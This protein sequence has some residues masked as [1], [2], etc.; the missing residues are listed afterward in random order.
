MSD[1]IEGAAYLSDYPAPK[2]IMSCE[3]CG[4]RVQYDKQAMLDAGGD[5]S[6]PELKRDIANRHHC[7][8]PGIDP[9]DAWKHCKA[10]YENAVSGYQK[11]KGR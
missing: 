2:L 1:R 9:M 10:S 7:K 4:W 5:R 8:Q 3:L 6:L 11:A